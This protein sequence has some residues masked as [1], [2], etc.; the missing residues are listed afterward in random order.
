MMTA[1]F[2]PATGF[3]PKARLDGM[4]IGL[5]P[6]VPNDWDALY[7]VGKDKKIWAGHPEKDRWR[8]EKFR[9]FWQSGIESPEGLYLIGHYN[10]GQII[11][12]SRFYGTTDCATRIGYT[13][14]AKEYW[15]TG[16]NDEL[17]ML[18]LNHAFAHKA[19]VFFDIGATNK[20]SRKAV[21]KLGARLSKKPHQGKVEYVLERGDAQGGG[22]G[23]CG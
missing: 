3:D 17:K 4:T 22:C 8:E 6:A 15:G 10:S 19:R 1:Q 23:C 12:T 20:R 18:M 7:A 14:L 16:T 11:G 5:R 21:E 13:F 9:A 2:D